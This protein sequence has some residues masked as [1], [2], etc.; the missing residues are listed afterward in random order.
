MILLTSFLSDLIAH[1]VLLIAVI[2]FIRSAASTRR[3]SDILMLSLVVAFGVVLVNRFFFPNFTF[4][5]L[6]Y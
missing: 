3:M 6:F 5:T 4:A 2:F 1:F